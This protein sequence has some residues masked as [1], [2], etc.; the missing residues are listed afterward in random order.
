MAGLARTVNLATGRVVDSSAPDPSA[1]EIAAEAARVAQETRE[2]NRRQALRTLK[3]RFKAGTATANDR[4]RALK[5]LCGMALHD[6][7]E[8]AE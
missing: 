8:D 1:E 7:A 2:R 6:L 3:D 4:D 5:I